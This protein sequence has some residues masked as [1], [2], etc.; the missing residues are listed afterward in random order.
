MVILKFALIRSFRNPIALLASFI[1]P[2]VLMLFT[3]LWVEGSGMFA[4]RGYYLIAM[5]MMFG[6]FPLTRG[7]VRERREKTI[8]R[9]M[10]TPTT[11]FDYLSQN[12]IAC[13]V[14]L[15]MQIAIVCTMG[16][17]MHDWTTEFTLWIGLL[18][19]VFAAT[20]VV[21]CFAWNCLFKNVEAGY[22]VLAAFLTFATFILTMPLS[23]FPDIVR[24]AFMIFPTYWIASGLDELIAYGATIQFG[25]AL[26]IMGVFS[27]IFLLYGSK[28]G[29]Y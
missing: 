3:D 11:T 9:I 4:R 28:R 25:I 27:A 19:V 10:S 8:I 26:A 14:P 16:M 5:V 21:F 29:A 12:L 6:A 13:M 24:N 15:L 20:S 23:L 7:M 1:L 22:T 17:V 2:V 18:Y